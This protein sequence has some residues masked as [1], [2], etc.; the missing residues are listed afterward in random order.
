MLLVASIVLLVGVWRAGRGSDERP[1]P[2]VSAGLGLLI[3]PEAYIVAGLLLSTGPAV[4]ILQTP[5][6][7]RNRSGAR[8]PRRSH[9]GAR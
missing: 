5:V 4:Y 1:S 3:G 2:V 7:P 6:K 9:P 8:D